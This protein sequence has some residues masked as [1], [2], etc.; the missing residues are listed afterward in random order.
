[1]SNSNFEICNSEIKKVGFNIKTGMSLSKK[2]TYAAPLKLK[3]ELNSN[4]KEIIN[5]AVW[6]VIAS[7]FFLTNDGN[8]KENLSLL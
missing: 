5:L 6:L 2:G 4:P 3:K 7:R 8:D 1:M